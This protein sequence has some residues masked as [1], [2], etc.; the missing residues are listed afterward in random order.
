[1][2]LRRDPL[3]TLTL[4]QRRLESAPAAVRVAT[5]IWPSSPMAVPHGGG[6]S[7]EQGLISPGRFLL[8]LK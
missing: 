3:Q 1:M 6:R 7:L 8:L 5:G 2:G 4:V